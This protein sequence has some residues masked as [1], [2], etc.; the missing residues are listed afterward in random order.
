VPSHAGT[1][2]SARLLSS[3]VSSP[4]I[5]TSPFLI[6]IYACS[7]TTASNYRLY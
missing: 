1:Y 6:L 5:F 4:L 7:L 2:S 3:R